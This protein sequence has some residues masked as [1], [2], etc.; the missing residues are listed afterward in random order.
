M[1]KTLLL[2]DDVCDCPDNELT[3]ECD[4]CGHVCTVR[5]TTPEGV[6]MEWLLDAG[7]TP[8]DL[9]GAAITDSAGVR[10]RVLQVADKLAAAL[11]GQGE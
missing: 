5:T 6:A 9:E 3:Y 7:I 10:H 11:A 1:S 4:E 8:D 2:I